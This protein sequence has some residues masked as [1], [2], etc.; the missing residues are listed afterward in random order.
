MPV[1]ASP[2]RF[3]LSVPELVARPA[4]ALILGHFRPGRRRVDQGVIRFPAGDSGRW[5]AH[6]A[7]MGG[8]QDNPTEGRGHPDP[9]QI[10][11][12][13]GSGNDRI[14][15]LAP[16]PGGPFRQE[17]Q[18]DVM[19]RSSSGD[20]PPSGRLST[21]TGMPSRAAASPTAAVSPSG[22]ASGWSSSTPSAAVKGTALPCRKRS[23][24]NPSARSKSFRIFSAA[25]R[26]VIAPR[27]AADDAQAAGRD[28]H[29]LGGGAREQA[30][31]ICA[32]ACRMSPGEPAAGRPP[33]GVPRR[34]RPHDGPA[35]P[36]RPGRRYSSP[37]RSRILRRHGRDGLRPARAG[38]RDRDHG[39]PGGQRLCTAPGGVPG[40]P[41]VG[42]HDQRVAGSRAGA[43]PHP[44][45][46][47]NR[48]RPGP[49]APASSRRAL[50]VLAGARA[51]D[52]HAAGGG[53]DRGR[54][55]QVQ[56]GD[57]VQRACLGPDHPVQRGLRHRF[58]L[59]P[60]QQRT[61]GHREAAEWRVSGPGILESTVSSCPGRSVSFRGP[62]FSGRPSG[63]APETDDAGR[64]QWRTTVRRRCPGGPGSGRLHLP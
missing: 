41:G 39:H 55:G 5:P 16:Q 8:V 10:G 49:P 47:R 58:P 44:G 2:R 3:P 11:V 59:V 19:G 18:V 30:T 61:E 28:R 37:C 23:A 17:L 27:S 24:S 6:A 22:S 51:H 45:R 29:V 34:A 31:R 63:V 40:L 35:W 56:P 1:I 46:G 50:R 43:P 48:G 53:Q 25:S 33:P 7:R 21:L 42:D 64:A 57:P 9:P 12:R 60:G 26:A 36:A 54:A 38:P 52:H 62:V 32:A 14:R 13:P 15:I 20:R 4:S